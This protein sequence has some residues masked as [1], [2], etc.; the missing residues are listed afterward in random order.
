M[1]QKILGQVYPNRVK[2][3]ASIPERIRK[4]FCEQ[5]INCTDK[6]IEI[7]KSHRDILSKFRQW[8]HMYSNHTCLA[9]I[10]RPPE[11]SASCRHSLCESC[12]IAHSYS[13]PEE[14]WKFNLRACPLC[15]KSNSVEFVLKPS[16]AGVRGLEI[17][18]EGG[19]SQDILTLQEIETQLQLS[20]P[21]SEHFD[22]V[23]GRDQG[24]S[25]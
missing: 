20:M 22:I 25:T 17:G 16:T 2:L 13:D 15:K 10:V 21:L 9:C 8:E 11:I 1:L 3:V 19:R 23:N 7:R 5:A 4:A 18:I 6:L 24:S 14:P 12:I